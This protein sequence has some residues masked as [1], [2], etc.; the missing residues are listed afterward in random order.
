MTPVNRN[1]PWFC[2]LFSIRST[3]TC[4]INI[5][6]PEFKLA[7]IDIAAKKRNLTRSAFLVQAAEQ[8]SF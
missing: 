7:R 4:R 3:K 2:V 5:T 6:V 1:T 8:T